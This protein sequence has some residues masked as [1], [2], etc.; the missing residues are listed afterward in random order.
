MA[1]R[2][3]PQQ[4]TLQTIS[5]IRSHN[6]NLAKLQQQAST[7]LRLQRP[8]DDPLA[9]RT[10]LSQRIED[11]RLGAELATMR[12]A[13]TQLNMSVSRLLD[14]NDVLVRAR[15]LALVGNQEPVEAKTLAH[16]VNTL[17]DQLLSIANTLNNE[18]YLFA[19]TATET[20]PFV[21]DSTDGVGDAQSVRYVAA[22]DR[23]NV[24]TGPNIDVDAIFSGAQVFQPS[25]RKE[26]IFGSSTGAAA[27][28]GTDSARGRGQLIVR[29]TATTY[30]PGSGVQAGIS[31][32]DGDTVIGPAGSHRLTVVDTSGTG[33]G[34]TVSLNGGAVVTF[35]S[36]DTDLRVVGPAGETVFIDTT[37]ITPGF[38]GDIAITADGTLSVDGGVSE[39]PIDFS[40]NQTLFDIPSGDVTNVDS[41]DIR[42]AGIVDVE[43]RG[44]ADAFEAL[45]AL[46]DELL[47][48]RN[49]PSSEWH[50]AMSRR[51]ED[52][53]RVGNH[54][55]SVVGEQSVALENLDTLEVRAQ[56]LQLERQRLIAEIESADISETVVNLQTEQ[57]LLQFT[58]ASSIGLLNTSLLDFLR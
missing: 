17:I 1:I 12:D 32:V 8:A 4:F 47:N 22:S 55:L 58:Y 14:A 46:R 6:A 5:S 45:I 36:G 16:Q 25:D 48:T 28:S 42:H 52:L 40:G 27:G 19:G 10:L 57:N 56:D 9:T 18:Q 11:N 31:S 2:V 7:G 44:T 13:R 53:Q 49:L 34:G 26:T 33:S 29:H 50:A 35:S 23:L 3:T 30:A 21:V 51:L 15:E 37:S 24:T 43:Y 39:T 38:N 54:V 41:T 20:A